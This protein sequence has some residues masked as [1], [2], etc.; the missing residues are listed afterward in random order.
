MKKKLLTFSMS[1]F[2]FLLIGIVITLVFSFLDY[3]DII[4]PLT[5]N[6][7]ISV[8]SSLLYFIFAVYTGYKSKKRGLLIGISLFFLYFLISFIIK[9]L[10]T[11]TSLSNLLNFILKSILLISGSIIGVN[12]SNRN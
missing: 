9:G 5:S 8:I 4:S 2:S 1:I 10:S 12:L 3:K 11:F 7:I 6:I